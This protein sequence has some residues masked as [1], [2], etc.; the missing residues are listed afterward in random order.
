VERQ[1]IARSGNIDV[2]IAAN[3]RTAATYS[4][5]VSVSGST[6]HSTTQQVQSNAP[7]RLVGD[8][9]IN[10]ANLYKNIANISAPAQQPGISQSAPAGRAPATFQQLLAGSG[11]KPTQTGATA[12]QAAPMPLSQGASGARQQPR[13]LNA[14]APAVHP[15]SSAGVASNVNTST[16][17]SAKVSASNK[18]DAE[19]ELLLGR[20]SSHAAEADADWSEGFGKRMDVLAKREYAQTKAA[21]VHCI[22]NV[23]P[24]PTTWAPD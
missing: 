5:A 13:A 7:Y 15:V 9:L 1:Q 17:A 19:I 16:T 4:A 18:L 21:E 2:I 22:G 11:V 14:G 10:T 8:T 12:L 24:L 23:T 6:G 3:A 20:T